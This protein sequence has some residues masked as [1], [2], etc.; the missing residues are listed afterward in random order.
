MFYHNHRIFKHGKRK[1]SSPMQIVSGQQHE[2]WLD[3]LL[4]KSAA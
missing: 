1:S 3:L 2:H 4:Q